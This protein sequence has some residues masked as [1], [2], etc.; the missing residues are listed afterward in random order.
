MEEPGLPVS[1][2]DVRAS[3]RA[4]GRSIRFLVPDAV[5]DYIAKRGLYL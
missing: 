1:A 4:S 5:A 3:G 2:T